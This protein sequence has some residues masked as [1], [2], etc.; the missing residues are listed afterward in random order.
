M[1]KIILLWMLFAALL[2]AQTDWERW[3]AAEVSYEITGSSADGRT[4]SGN[5]AGTGLL[6]MAK[7]AYTFFISDHDGDNCPFYPSCSNFFVQ[8]VNE[9]NIFQGLLMFAD[10]FTRD[11]NFFKY[12]GMYPV[13]KSGKFFDPVCNYKLDPEKILIH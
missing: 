4:S 7:S 11:S 13:H 10:R 1:M 2:R 9:T 8:A 6:G 3:S 12:R 5:A